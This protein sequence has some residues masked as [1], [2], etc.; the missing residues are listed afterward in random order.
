MV[1]V[2]ARCHR[3]GSKLQAASWRLSSASSL[4]Y[5]PRLMV[6]SL[7]FILSMSRSKDSPGISVLHKASVK[8]ESTEEILR[9]LLSR[10]TQPL[11]HCQPQFPSAT[12]DAFLT[13]QPMNNSPTTHHCW[14]ARKGHIAT[15]CWPQI[16]T[17][18]LWMHKKSNIQL[19]SIHDEQVK[20]HRLWSTG[21]YVQ[22]L[23]LLLSI[24]FNFR[25]IH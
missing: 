22:T 3:S 18:I 14:M 25:Y 21:S 17:V 20:Q 6:S 15:T 16:I 1:R 10:E 9:R 11:V 2:E 19:D 8:L 24:A 13:F 23:V 7:I 12:L 5:E 4:H